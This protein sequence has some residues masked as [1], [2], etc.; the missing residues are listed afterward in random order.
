MLTGSQCDLKALECK[1]VWRSTQRSVGLPLSGNFSCNSKFLHMKH[2]IV[3]CAGVSLSG[4]APARWETLLQL[5]IRKEKRNFGFF[6]WQGDARKQR[7]FSC[8]NLWRRAPTENCYGVH[9]SVNKPVYN[10]HLQA[11]W[12][13]EAPLEP[14]FPLSQKRLRHTKFQSKHDRTVPNP[15]QIFDRFL[16]SFEKNLLPPGGVFSC[17]I[18]FLRS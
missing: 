18:P 2:K 8:F 13:I 4:N 1:G 10:H 14:L 9:I 5:V 15:Q 11:L 7:F 16:V 6:G 3:V 12:S 17:S